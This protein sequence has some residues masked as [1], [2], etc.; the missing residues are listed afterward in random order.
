MGL[1]NRDEINALIAQATEED[2]ITQYVAFEKVRKILAHH[3]VFL[4][5]TFLDG[6]DRYIVIPITRFGEKLGQTDDGEVKMADEDTEFTLYFE[7]FQNETGLYTIF[8]EIVNDA[9]L[10]EL[11]ADYENEKESLNEEKE[12][13]ITLNIPL[14]LRVMEF[15]KED[16][17]DDE[18]LHIAA[19]KMAELGQDKMLTMKDY[20]KIVQEE[21][22]NDKEPPFTPDK[23]RSTPWKNPEAKAKQLA[24]A[25]MRK[26]RDR[27]Q[28]QGKN[29]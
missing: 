26:Y 17:K 27:G 12:K 7:W 22:E 24:R 21:K 29:D 23:K 20:M 6:S 18:A 16:A 2:C 15:S 14:L 19:E 3:H 5:R 13:G 25:A 8:S 11:V 9:E 4:P 1:H 10:Q 28:K